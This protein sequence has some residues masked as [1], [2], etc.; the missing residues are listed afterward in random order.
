MT[1]EELIQ[2]YPD[3]ATYFT[4]MPRELKSRYTIRT[5]PPGTIIHQ[6]DYPLDYFGIVCSGDHRDLHKEYRRQRQMCI[7]DRY[8]NNQEDSPFGE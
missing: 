3:V 8:Q 7:R 5:F 4:Y 6:K 1:L 2:A